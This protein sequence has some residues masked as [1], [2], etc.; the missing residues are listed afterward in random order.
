MMGLGSDFCGH[1]LQ[2]SEIPSNKTG[3]YITRDPQIL[4]YIEKHNF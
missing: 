3:K 1:Q 2:W 4:L